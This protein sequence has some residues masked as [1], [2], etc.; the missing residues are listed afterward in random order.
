MSTIKRDIHFLVLMVS[1]FS[2]NGIYVFSLCDCA[3]QE[4]LATYA[5]VKIRGQYSGV[6]SLF[7][8]VDPQDL[9]LVIR[10]DT[11]CDHPGALLSHS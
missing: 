3:G 5:G 4:K 8:R 7:P 9:T 10:L 6:G 11:P 2:K 1:Y